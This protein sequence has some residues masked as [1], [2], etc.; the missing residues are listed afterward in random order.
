MDKEEWKSLLQM[1]ETVTSE[2]KRI[3]FDLDEGGE[4]Q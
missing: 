1:T 4:A 3:S 2:I